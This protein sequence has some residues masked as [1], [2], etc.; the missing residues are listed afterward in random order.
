MSLSAV[1]F[2]WCQTADCL[3]PLSAALPD[4]GL[5]YV[6]CGARRRTVLCPLWCQTADYLMPLS[7]ALPDG[8]LSYAPIGVSSRSG[9][10]GLCVGN[11]VWTKLPKLAASLREFVSLIVPLLWVCPGPGC[12][13]TSQAIYRQV[14]RHSASLMQLLSPDRCTDVPDWVTTSAMLTHLFGIVTVLMFG[15][16][17]AS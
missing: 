6:P 13:T 3:M 12:T 11:T 9:D 15:A 7:A 17:V 1:R 10:F 2:L 4:G 16:M 8:G 5:S 14:G